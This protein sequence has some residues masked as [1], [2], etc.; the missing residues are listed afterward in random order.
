MTTTAEVEGSTPLPYQHMT[1]FE[2]E[3]FHRRVTGVRVPSEIGYNHDTVPT[4][5]G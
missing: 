5:Y 3:L 4:K 2:K 1:D